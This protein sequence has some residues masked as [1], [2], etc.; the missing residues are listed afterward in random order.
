MQRRWTPVDYS[1]R[2]LMGRDQGPWKWTPPR[3][4]VTQAICVAQKAVA[5][6]ET[7]RGRSSS[8]HGGS[9]LVGGRR[10][11]ADFDCLV[12]T[13]SWAGHWSAERSCRVHS[14]RR[15]R[16][17]TCVCP[18]QLDPTLHFCSSLQCRLLKAAE[19]TISKA[20]SGASRIC[21][22]SDLAL[23][24]EDGRFH[25]HAAQ[26]KQSTTTRSPDMRTLPSRSRGAICMLAR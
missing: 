21:S 16:Q 10:E 6:M 12:V 22:S 14:V 24:F 3:T 11:L 1:A 23:E 19:D 8:L 4:A 25:E 26:S 18:C 20:S 7:R 2:L 9:S 13:H 17:G 15:R 5:L